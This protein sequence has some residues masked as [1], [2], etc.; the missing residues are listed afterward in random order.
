MARERPDTLG[1]LR[2]EEGFEPQTKVLF[3]EC[4]LEY[5]DFEGLTFVAEKL[6]EK[7]IS[8]GEEELNV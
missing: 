6:T 1:S 8:I 4:A 2:K 5:L 3:D 7:L